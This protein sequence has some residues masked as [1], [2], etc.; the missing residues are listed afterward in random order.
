MNILAY[1]Y[2]F[3][4]LVAWPVARIFMRAG[5]APLW[6]ALLLVPAY[7]LILCTFVLAVRKWPA[8]AKG[9]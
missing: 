5:F 2:I 3:A 4:L 1:Y 9:A 8:T 6:A 7:G